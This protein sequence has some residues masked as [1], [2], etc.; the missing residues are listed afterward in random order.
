[1]YA[2]KINFDILKLAAQMI[3]FCYYQLQPTH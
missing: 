2:H 3:T 1:M